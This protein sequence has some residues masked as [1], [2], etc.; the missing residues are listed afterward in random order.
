MII[1]ISIYINICNAQLGTLV[2]LTTEQKQEILDKHNDVR[3][4]VASGT[5]VGVNGALPGAT[6]MNEL[7]WVW[8]KKK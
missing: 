3:N 8:I 5:Y 7:L 1:L 4:E 2:T 6:N